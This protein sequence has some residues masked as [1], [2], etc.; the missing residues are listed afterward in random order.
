MISMKNKTS[1]PESGLT[2]YELE[3]E[4]IVDRIKALTV[5]GGITLLKNYI[6]AKTINP[7]CPKAKSCEQKIKKQKCHK[8]PIIITKWYETEGWRA[9]IADNY[10][11]FKPA[12]IDEINFEDLEF[13]FGG[14]GFERT[15]EMEDQYVFKYKRDAVQFAKEC[16]KEHLEGRA[17]IWHF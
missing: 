11:D 13:H 14:S 3:L 4:K 12:Y 10:D 1:H 7:I 6:P 9:E 16:N 15:D 5:I 17:K 2:D 8:I